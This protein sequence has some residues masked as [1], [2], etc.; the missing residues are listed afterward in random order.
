[1]SNFDL[2]KNSWLEIVFED[3]N[4]NYGAYQ[5]RQE[6]GKNTLKALFT[7]MALLGLVFLLVSFTEKKEVIKP[8]PPKLPEV[9]HI[10]TKVF[11][12]P[13]KIEPE[14][15]VQPKG[16][17][18]TKRNLNPDTP[19]QVVNETTVKPLGNINLP[20]N[21]NGSDN[22]TNSGTEGK[23][24]GETKTP[25]TPNGGS[26]GGTSTV[27]NIVSTNASFPGG[28]NAFREKVAENFTPPSNL[29]SSTITFEV[30]FI[31]ETD[32]SITDIRV[33]KGDK[34][35]EKEAIRTLKSIKKK[36]IPAE[37]NGQAVRMEKIMPIIIKVQEQ[38]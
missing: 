15:R 14:K 21:P 25:I 36:W 27:T 16:T 37:V 17:N 9:L 18:D 30:T 12:E 7:M 22:G 33:T 2:Q 8:G 23:P 38:D 11:V 26:T 31:I 28:I 3:K 35:F 13:E 34:K 19:T 10:D 1:M 24:E 32:G 20:H 29:E 5:L 6:D 4:K